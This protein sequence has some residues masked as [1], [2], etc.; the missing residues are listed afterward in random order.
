MVNDTGYGRLAILLFE[1]RRCGHDAT[2]NIR[3]SRTRANVGFYHEQSFSEPARNDCNVPGADLG[4]GVAASL[5]EG[6]VAG[7]PTSA[8]N[9]DI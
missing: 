1:T 3:R 7:T 6:Q 5:N 4:L 9:G 8:L 2:T